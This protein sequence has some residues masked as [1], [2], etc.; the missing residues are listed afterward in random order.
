MN[1]DVPICIECEYYQMFEAHGAVGYEAVC[2][3]RSRHGRLI[4]YQYGLGR[5]WTRDELKDRMASRISPAWCPK[6]KRR[7]QPNE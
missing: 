4:D 7:Q 5:K 1:N 2:K 3:A 6:R